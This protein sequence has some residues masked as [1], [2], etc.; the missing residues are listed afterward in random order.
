MVTRSLRSYYVDVIPSGDMKWDED[1]HTFICGNGKDQCEK[2][3]L[4]YCAI[5]EYSFEI[6]HEF[7]RCVQTCFLCVRFILD[8]QVQWIMSIVPVNVFFFFSTAK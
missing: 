6:V 3:L 4:Q 7:V 1:S 2:Q 8:I 5:R